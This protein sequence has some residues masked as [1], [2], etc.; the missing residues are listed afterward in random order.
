M[1]WCHSGAVL[2]PPPHIPH[3]FLALFQVNSR[4]IPHQLQEELDTS[5]TVFIY[6]LWVRFE[7][8]GG[9]GYVCHFPIMCAV[10]Y[11]PP[12]I[13]EIPVRLQSGSQIPGG[14]RF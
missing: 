1:L 6:Y 9:I 10:V 14:F 8:V 7:G 12:P 13:L 3:H 11:T 2:Y 4:F 5:V